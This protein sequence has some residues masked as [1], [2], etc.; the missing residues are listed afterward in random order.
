[1]RRFL[2]LVFAGVSLSPLPAQRQAPDFHQAAATQQVIAANSGSDFVVRG[3]RLFENGNF[4]IRGNVKFDPAGGELRV[5]NAHVVVVGDVV[6][7]IHGELHVTDSTFRLQNRWQSEHNYTWREGKLVTERAVIGGT[8]YATATFWLNNGLWIAR[9]TTIEHSGGILLG[10]SRHGYLG[11]PTQRG[12]TLI[13]DGLFQ[14]NVADALHMSGWGDATVSNSDFAIGLYVYADGRQASTTR[15][16]LDSGRPHT[17]VFGD[18]AVYSGVTRPLR[19][20]PARLELRNVRVPR[21]Q[22]TFFD[23]RNGGAPTKLVLDNA[24]QVICSFGGRNVTGSPVLG[25]SWGPRPPGLPSTR[26]PGFHPIPPGNSVTLANATLEAGN[27]AAHV[28]GWGLYFTGP[29]TD[30]AIR[31]ASLIVEQ[32]L[33]DGRMLLEGDGDWS[34]GVHANSIQLHGDAMLTIRKAAIGEFGAFR[35]TGSQIVAHGRATCDMYDV[36]LSDVRLATEWDDLTLNPTAKNLNEGRITVHRGFE[37]GRIDRAP[38]G[39][40]TV[41]IA[42]ALPGQN[43]DLQNLDLEA[44]VNGGRPDYW[45]TTGVNGARSSSRP[46]GS[47]GSWSFRYRTSGG[48]GSLWKSLAV[49][50]G[51]YV[52]LLGWLNVA[53]QNATPLA[54]R[55]AGANNANRSSAGASATGSWQFVQVPIYGALTGETGQILSIDDGTGGSTDAL[56]DDLRVHV[57]AWWDQDNLANLSF[58]DPNAYRSPGLAPDFWRGPDSWLVWQANCEPD[59]PRT[60]SGRSVRMTTTAMQGTIS[61]QLSFTRPGDRIAIRGF[62]RGIAAPGAS[63]W[64]KAQIGEGSWLGSLAQNPATPGD[65]SWV[66]FDVQGH[67]VPPRSSPPAKWEFT[68][69]IFECFGGAGNRMWIDDVEVEI[70]R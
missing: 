10:W 8:P 30:I 45:Y 59:A 26:L 54:L 15:L 29:A 6:L 35:I 36:R 37:Q 20:S 32:Y 66:R 38:A 39:N 24:D 53:S 4:L 11:D 9:Q 63:C 46:P 41:D 50:P 12:G 58:D 55:I 42:R 27:R 47:S 23:I 25:G 64:L 52:H 60:G 43:N 1:M 61:K 7:G 48:G 57:A 3:T 19:E 33:D 44:P 40:G 69:V 51:A 17:D 56:V 34:M 13:A 70:S 2:S 68:H 21:W 18:P 22:I 31:G 14:G 67:V 5:R 62:V 49:E 65:G 16:D 28:F